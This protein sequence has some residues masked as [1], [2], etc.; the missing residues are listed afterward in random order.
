VSKKLQLLLITNLFPTP[1]D[2]V[3]GVFIYQLV[4]ELTSLCDITV[5][6]P[7]PWFPRIKSLRFLK[8]WYPFSLV[9]KSYYVNDVKVYSPKYLIIPRVSET[10]HSVLMFLGVIK[11]ALTLH[12]RGRFDTINVQWLYPDGVVAYWVAKILR[13]PLSVSGLGCDVNLFLEQKEK[14]L[15]IVNMLKHVDVI[16][17]VSE[18]MKRRLLEEGVQEQKT[19]FSDL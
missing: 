6:C 18:S 2:P 17:V 19:G 8:K 5:V 14:K 1:V 13:L 12:R 9:P 7:L 10:I 16:T 3:R 4:Q 11:I 15:Q